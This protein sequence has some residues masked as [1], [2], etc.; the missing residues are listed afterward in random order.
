MSSDSPT[1]LRLVSALATKVS[2]SQPVLSAQAIGSSLYGLQ[3]LS[4]EALEVRTLV[5]ALN[6]KVEQTT[7]GLDAQAISN[8]L[9]GLQRMKSNAPE[10]R[11]L[12]QTL[13]NK[14]VLLDVQMTPKDIGQSLYG[15]H[16]LS[17]DVPQ[18]RALLA[19][20]ADR[21]TLSKCELG[22][23]DVA[24]ALYGMFSMTTDCPELRALL[25]AVSDKINAAEGKLDAQDIGNALYGLQGVSSD[26]YEA[27]V[28]VAKLAMK[29]RRSKAILRSQHIGRALLGLQH[30]S[31]EPAEVR[32]L[33]KEL[34]KRIA[35]SDR[36]KMTAQSIADALFGLQGM[37]SKIPEVQE[38]VGELAKKIAS[39]G[40]VLNSEQLGRALFGLQGLS[41]D[42][43]LFEES[44]IGL[45][46]DEVQF[47][48][49]T[50]WDKVKVRREGMT[51]GAIGMGLQ[52]ITLLKDPIASN[53][54]QYMYLQ[55]L[56]LGIQREDR[57]LVG[58]TALEDKQAIA[59]AITGDA[60]D[61]DKS[62][63]QPAQQQAVKES[64]VPEHLFS[65]YRTVK[66]NNL[67]I[68]RWIQLEYDELIKQNREKPLL[69]QSRADKLVTQRF[70]ARYPDTDM[71]TNEFNEGFHMDMWFPELQLNIELDG[72]AHRYPARLRYDRM[73]DDFFRQKLN[74]LVRRVLLFGRSI[75]EVVEEIESIVASTGDVKA[76]KDIQSIYSSNND[77]QRLYSSA[78]NSASSDAS[79]TSTAASGNADSDV[80]ALMNILKLLGTPGAADATNGEDQSGEQ[81]RN[82]KRVWVRN[83]NGNKQQPRK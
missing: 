23:Q 13:A 47:L 52:G 62:A 18:V 44:A 19:A 38:L 73:R 15:L 80:N 45:D 21:I 9:F 36:T 17:S 57:P 82:N 12:V 3:K 26:M 37:T 66:L 11:S 81:G 49:S 76:E 35:D 53:L 31:A 1:V 51:L 14:I 41:S 28:I 83:V 71:K 6:E 46:S 20:L 77:I 50:L 7:T 65:V 34:A 60:V 68:P 74:V 25:T 42:A 61:A 40:A 10:V 43:A 72:P 39:T 29:I 27:R 4:S 58:M 48:L 70:I 75:D 2:E 16:S 33:I 24:D 22:A 55:L 64:I 5:A 69:T 8:A 63:S 78:G 67:V 32:M 59:N 79:S 54:R 30:F 56:R